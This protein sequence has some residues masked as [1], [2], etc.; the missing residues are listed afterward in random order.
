MCLTPMMNIRKSCIIFEPFCPY[1]R[2]VRFATTNDLLHRGSIANLL[3]AV[4]VCTSSQSCISTITEI[5][6]GESGP[7]LVVL[8]VPLLS[9]PGEDDSS[10][11]YTRHDS[12][13]D[14]DVL[15]GLPLLKFLCREMDSMRLSNKFIPI[16]LVS[17]EDAS[18]PESQ[19]TADGLGPIPQR[20]ELQCIDNG[21][22]DA[23]ARRLTAEKAR[24]LYMHC[25]RLGSSTPTTR[26][27]KIP[28]A[29]G[30]AVEVK[31]DEHDNFAYLRE[32]MFVPLIPRDG[33]M[34][35]SY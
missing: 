34:L 30:K 7:T 5:E 35:T 8:D 17:N 2:Q 14:T 26:W 25:Y 15:Y 10:S 12:G 20:R 28:L 16:A 9:Q 6:H 31:K 1:F 33:E 3:S 24:D 32:E 4:T 22:F 13:L 23:T 27:A 19:S 29:S 21:A 11:M 18:R